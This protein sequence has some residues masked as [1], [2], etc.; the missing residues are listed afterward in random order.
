MAYLAEEGF[1]CE[2]NLDAYHGTRENQSS[3]NQELHGLGVLPFQDQALTLLLCHD[4]VQ[5]IF[6]VLW[7]SR[8]YQACLQSA[9]LHDSGR[10][11]LPSF[12]SHP[13]GLFV[14]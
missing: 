5:T 9:I 12:I 2:N 13:P 14:L 10:Y 7:R 8:H 4:L 1:M 3:D 11:F 6:L